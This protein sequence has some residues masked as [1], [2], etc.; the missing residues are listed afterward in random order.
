M[1]EKSEPPKKAEDAAEPE[2]EYKSLLFGLPKFKPD[3]EKIVLPEEMLTDEAI[4]ARA[5]VY[6][7]KQTSTITPP[8]NLRM[9]DRTHDTV[10]LKWNAGKVSIY[11]SKSVL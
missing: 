10:T 2:E 7:I 3:P 9:V 4:A 11:R 8:S 1:A 5:G 6:E